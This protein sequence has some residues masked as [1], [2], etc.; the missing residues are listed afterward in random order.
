MTMESTPQI[1]P[2]PK[3]EPPRLNRGNSN[4]HPDGSGPWALLA[5]DLR[6]HDGDP[7]EQGSWAAA[8]QRFGN[9]RMGVRAKS[10]R[11]PLTLLY[12]STFKRVDWTRGITLPYTVRPGRRMRIGHHGGMVLHARSI[13]EDVPIRQNTA[14]GAAGAGDDLRIP[15]IG[16]RADIG[17]GAC[18]LGDVTVGPESRTG[19]NAAAPIDVPSGSTAAGVPA[20]IVRPAGLDDEVAAHDPVRRSNDGR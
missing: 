14:F 11:A 2:S 13:G 8:V 7:F 4:G 10:L 20:R 16:E 6:P 9:W 5:E 19:A 3:P 12:R 15:A 1:R 17:C 18:I